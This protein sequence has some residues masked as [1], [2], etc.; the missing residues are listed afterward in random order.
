ML[1][2]GLGFPP[3][4]HFFSSQRLVLIVRLTQVPGEQQ[5]VAGPEIFLSP[6]CLFHF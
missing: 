3:R 1:D 6:L 2:L 5:A 4:F